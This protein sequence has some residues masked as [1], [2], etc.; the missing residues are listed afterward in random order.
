MSKS[1]LCTS[2]QIKGIEYCLIS[3]VILII[4][5]KQIVV[6]SR[7]RACGAC[8]GCKAKE[9]GKCGSCL[10]MKKFGGPGRK[11]QKC[12][13]RKCVNAHSPGNFIIYIL[14]LST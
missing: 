11:K 12:D 8:V 10:D 14:F 9:C 4:V 13:E 7:K 6:I 2:T 3:C 1:T 5:C